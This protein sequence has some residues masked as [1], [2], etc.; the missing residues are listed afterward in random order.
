MEYQ[1]NLFDVPLYD[2][3][4]NVVAILSQVREYS[5]GIMLYKLLYPMYSTQNP[6]MEFMHNVTFEFMKEN[7]DFEKTQCDYNKCKRIFI[8]GVRNQSSIESGT[9]LNEPY[10]HLFVKGI[11]KYS[12]N[13]VDILLEEQYHK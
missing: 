13:T 11:I 3:S 12:G 2:D 6:D 5:N 7:D 9:A 10:S 8:K 1:Y 4:N